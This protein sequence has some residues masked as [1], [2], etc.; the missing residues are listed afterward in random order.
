[1]RELSPPRRRTRLLV[2]AGLAGGGLGLSAAVF[3]AGGDRPPPG[4][5]VVPA[6]D[7]FMIQHSIT[8]GQL[9]AQP[10]HRATPSTAG[11]P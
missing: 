3:L 6:V 7:V 1:W 9:P 10:S 8:T 4:P 5:K 2:T 11:V